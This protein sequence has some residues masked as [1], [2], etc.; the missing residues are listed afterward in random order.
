M[1]SRP[2][3]QTSWSSSLSRGLK[4]NRLYKRIVSGTELRPISFKKRQQ[5]ENHPE[6]FMARACFPNVF[7]FPIRE[8]LFSSVSFC[9][10]LTLHGRE[11]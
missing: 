2:S 8:T 6:T 5:N 9:A 1:L 11:L 7:Q 10:M 4:I 3:L